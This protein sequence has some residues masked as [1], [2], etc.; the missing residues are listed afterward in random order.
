[1]KTKTRTHRM[2]LS[3]LLLF[4]CMFSLT[5]IALGGCSSI[6]D[7][8]DAI[9]KQ[10]TQSPVSAAEITQTGLAKSSDDAQPIDAKEITVG[11]TICAYCTIDNLDT[12]TS[13]SAQW[14]LPDGSV[15]AVDTLA[16]NRN[17]NYFFEQSISQLGDYKVEF[18]LDGKD[19]VEYTFCVAETK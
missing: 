13:V 8:H 6:D 5:L 14:T 9:V 1:M 18:T 19:A 15:S 4:L 2:R 7:D 11:D 10:I 17:D 16:V 3:E 12:A